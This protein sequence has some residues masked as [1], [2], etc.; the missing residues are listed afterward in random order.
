MQETTVQELKKLMDEGA[1]F[2]LIDVREPWEYKKCN[3]GG[4]S[5]PMSEAKSAESQIATDKKVIIH[6]YRGIRSAKVI[7]E[8]EKTY[9][10]TNLYNLKGGLLAYAKE[11][12]PNLATY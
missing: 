4:I 8:L 2:Q 9:G 3:I 12:D 1:D 10:F 7:A 11:I 6:C 5:I